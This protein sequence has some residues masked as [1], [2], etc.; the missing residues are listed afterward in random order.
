M[1]HLANEKTLKFK[2]DEKNFMN[3]FYIFKLN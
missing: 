2:D 1:L 3:D